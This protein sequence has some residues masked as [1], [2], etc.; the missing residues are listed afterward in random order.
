[1][2]VFLCP[3]NHQ[4]ISNLTPVESLHTQI[5]L[6]DHS[7]VHEYLLQKKIKKNTQKK[8]I[9]KKSKKTTTKNN[10]NNMINKYLR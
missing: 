3:H 2:I 7:T 8:R 4:E 5:I 9:Q 1:M 6:T 10:I